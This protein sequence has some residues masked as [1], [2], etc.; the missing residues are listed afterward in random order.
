M[1]NLCRYCEVPTEETDD[2]LAD[3]PLKPTAKI[4][5][6]IS[7]NDAEGLQALS[8]HK[9]EN[10]M[11]KVQFGSHSKQGI[12]GAC[13]VELLHAMYLGIMKY[14]CDCLFE[15]M[16]KESKLA[17]YVNSLSML[18]GELLSCQSNCDLPVT[19]FSNGIRKGKIM[20]QEYPGILLCMAAVF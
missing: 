19:K 17:G 5:K 2:P 6:L 18:Y 14:T 11:Y 10:D 15:Q 16:G 20:A 12:H 3:Y 9:I 1:A 13:L 4:A 7:R 8:Q